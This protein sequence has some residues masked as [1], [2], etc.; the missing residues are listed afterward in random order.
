MGGGDLT[1]PERSRWCQREGG[2]EGATGFTKFLAKEE[3]PPMHLGISEMYHKYLV[4]VS[5]G[6]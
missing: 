4:G 2:Q 1:F 6:V 5:C 3:C